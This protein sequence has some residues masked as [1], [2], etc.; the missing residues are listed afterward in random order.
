M[1]FWNGLSMI[2]VE[3]NVDVSVN[4]EVGLRLT[5]KDLAVGLQFSGTADLNHIVSF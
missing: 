5:D 2:P 4:A 3:V 1:T